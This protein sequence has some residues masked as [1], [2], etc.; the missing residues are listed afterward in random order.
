[1]LGALSADVFVAA[2]ASLARVLR[3]PHD[4][5]DAQLYLHSSV[6]EVTERVHAQVAV[7]WLT[8]EAQGTAQTVVR[9]DRV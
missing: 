7:A 5:A 2:C 8:L 4:R 1:M 9:P 6:A 3:A